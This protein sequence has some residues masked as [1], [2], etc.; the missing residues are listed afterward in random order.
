[1]GGPPDLGN[2]VETAAVGAQL[3]VTRCAVADITTVAAEVRPLVMVMSA[4]V[5]D[6]D[7]ES[8]VRLARVVQSRLLIVRENQIHVD[9]LEGKL[10]DLM[11]EV[12]EEA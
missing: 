6:F 1:V 11:L 12:D 4:E 10:K 8:I 3:L 2:A 5:F 9:T 7:P